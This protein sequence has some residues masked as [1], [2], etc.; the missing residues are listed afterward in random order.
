MNSRR[1]FI[2]IVPISGLAWIAACSDKK[3]DSAAVPAPAPAPVAAAPAP[4]PTAAP[5]AA[6]APAAGPLP[7]VGA[8]DPVGISLGYVAEAAK[9]DV[10]KFPKYAAGQACSNC[11]LYQG[12]A[13][14]AAGGCP[15]FAGKQVAAAGWCSGY[16]KKA[17]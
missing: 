7:M 9:A 8:S 16:T 4:A 14:D 5:S 11:A 2:Q 17:G 13:G 12:K 1:R 15:L 10:A 3:A 6:P